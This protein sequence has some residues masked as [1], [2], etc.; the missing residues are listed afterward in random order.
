LIGGV[1]SITQLV[2]GGATAALVVPA[3]DRRKALVAGFALGTLPDLD[4][5]YL[6]LADLDGVARVT[7]HRGPTHSLFVLAAI[8]FVIW[9]LAKRW[10][11]PVAEHPRRWFF[12]VELS[13]LTH[14]LLDIFT[15]YGTQLFWPLPFRP[16]MGSSISIVDPAYTLPLVVACVIAAC[17]GKSKTARSAIFGCVVLSHAYLG[18]TLVGQAIVE[19]RA[20]AALS[21]EGLA[22]AGLVAT[23]TF[24]NSVRWIVV[25]MSPTG[26]EEGFFS[27]ANPDAPIVF[28]HHES[29]VN[30]LR[31]IADLPAV[32]R[33]EWFTHG[34]M[35]AEVSGDILLVS[36]IRM[37][38]YPHYFFTYEIARKDGSG[39]R[40]IRP[41][42]IRRN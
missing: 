8:G 18:W 30:A 5:V 36:D 40:A 31:A 19:S 25:A 22:N 35:K 10:F 41:E 3:E 9:Y 23:P 1:D 24:G 15:T 20:R 29:D 38:A 7:W 21:G 16:I 13:L 28:T 4:E 42:L 12:A 27:F 39:W 33:L 6:S 14:P 17:L 26:Y 2:L 11:K 37:G 32:K 34:F